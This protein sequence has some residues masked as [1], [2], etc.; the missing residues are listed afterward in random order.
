[1]RVLTRWLKLESCG[2][3]YI[4]ALHLSYL[5]IKFDDE[6]KGNLFEVQAYFLIRLFQKLNWRL[7]LVLCASDFAVSETCNTNLWQRPKV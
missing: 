5:H 1:M 2:F 6:I 4:L 3:R 7:G